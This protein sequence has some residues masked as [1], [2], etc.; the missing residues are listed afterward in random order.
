[1]HLLAGYPPNVAVA[2]LLSSLKG[3]SAPTPRQRYRIRANREH[4]WSPS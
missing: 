3:V 4:L 1:V 2:A